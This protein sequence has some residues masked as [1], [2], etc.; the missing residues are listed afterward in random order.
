MLDDT[1]V[2]CGG[3]FGRTVYSQ[4]KFTETTYGR[5]HHPK[6]FSLWVAGA[7]VKG[8]MT[9]GDTDKYSFNITTP[10]Q[11]VHVRDLHATILERCGMDY[12]K[13]KFSYQG[14]DQKLTG[15]EEAK[16]VRDIL[17]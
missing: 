14:L 2:I 10:D 12:H 5:D 8:G 15:V 1:L 7:G 4:G 3:E 13:L 9:Y 6:A 11:K 17:D 16:V